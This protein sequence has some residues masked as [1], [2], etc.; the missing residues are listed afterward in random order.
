MNL[1]HSV[2]FPFLRLFLHFRVVF[3]IHCIQIWVSASLTAV[4][5]PSKLPYNDL[6]AKGLACGFR[7]PTADHIS[8]NR[9]TGLH[10][11]SV[12]YDGEYVA[13]H[14]GKIGVL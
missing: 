13:R 12:W 9:E 3:C 1:G 7:L 4:I 5:G 10:S 6:F 11:D 14:I 2:Q 8:A